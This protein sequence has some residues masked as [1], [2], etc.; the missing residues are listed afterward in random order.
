MESSRSRA[1][2]SSPSPPVPS[3]RGQVDGN[4]YVS[5]FFKTPQNQ[6]I[7]EFGQ[8]GISNGTISMTLETVEKRIAEDGILDD[9]CVKKQIPAVQSCIVFLYAWE[10]FWKLRPEDRVA[11]IKEC[12]DR[13]SN[14]FDRLCRIVFSDASDHIQ[15]DNAAFER[16][17]N[18]AETTRRFFKQGGATGGFPLE[19]FA[20]L[21]ASS[22]NCYMVS[23]CTWYTL[24]LQRQ[25][26]K[27]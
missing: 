1:P 15:H 18:M 11:R 13:Q 14:S 25:F 7:H 2:C 27:A 6:P 8:L 22:S 9:A 23:A 21:H 26:P 5:K 3:E 24:M 4:A 19:P 10:F 20:R 12:L 17:F 16:F